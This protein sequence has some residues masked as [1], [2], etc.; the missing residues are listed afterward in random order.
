[1]S[2]ATTTTAT[3]TTTT[4]DTTS[5][6]LGESALDKLI[7]AADMHRLR[8]V[9]HTQ[10]FSAFRE[11]LRIARDTVRQNEEAAEQDR[12]DRERGF[13]RWVDANTPNLAADLM[14]LDGLDEATKA[15]LIHI[16][17]HGHPCEYAT[18]LGLARIAAKEATIK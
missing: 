10:G 4:T 9:Y 6:R 17:Q 8:G 2:D 11:H 16:R 1:M 13:R 7:P 12:K 18:E 15:R 3:T 5:P 14:N